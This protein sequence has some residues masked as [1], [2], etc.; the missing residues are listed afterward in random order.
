MAGLDYRTAGESHGKGCVVLV[1][2]MPAGV[3]LDL[4]MVNAELGRRQGGYGRSGRQRK[5]TR[6]TGA[7]RRTFATL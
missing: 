5:K 4:N 2:G 1:E 7:L 6:R 3:P